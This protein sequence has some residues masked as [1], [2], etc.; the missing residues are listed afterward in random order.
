MCGFAKE[1]C[2]LEAGNQQTNGL[3][4]DRNAEDTSHPTRGSLKSGYDLSE[5]KAAARMYLRH[6]RVFL[7]TRDLASR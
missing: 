2:G 7:C 6:L 4:R 5:R 1:S 3:S